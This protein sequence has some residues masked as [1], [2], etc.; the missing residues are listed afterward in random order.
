MTMDEV[1]VPADSVVAI[2]YH[3][4][5]SS[6]CRLADKLIRSGTKRIHQSR[7]K[8]FLLERCVPAVPQ[9]CEVAT[10]KL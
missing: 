1:E 3:H 6:L 9:V 7:R 5:T 4:D 10:E 8:T 2:L